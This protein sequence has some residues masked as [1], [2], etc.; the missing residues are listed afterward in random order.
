MSGSRVLVS[1]SLG[2]LNWGILTTQEMTLQVLGVE[3][4][5][6]AVRARELA[7]RILDGNDG[8][9]C[10][11]RASRSG[12]RASRSAGKDAA[13]ALRA[14]HVSRLVAIAHTSR[15]NG[16]RS[17]G[18]V[19]AGL[20]HDATSRH[21][22]KDGRDATGGRSRRDGLR[23]RGSHRGLGQHR[24][25]A[26]ALGR[27]RVLAHLLVRTAAS[28]LSSRLL[29]VGGHV[30]RRARSVG[31]RGGARSVRVAAVHL[32][33]GRGGLRLKRRQSLVRQ[34]RVGVLQLVRRD[35]GRRRVGGRARVYTIGR[36]LGR[37]HAIRE[38]DGLLSRQR[39][40][41]L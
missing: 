4:S 36:V 12:G 33:H 31:G 23:V 38:S 27:G 34:G 9:L 39:R 17:V 16:A 41:E 5:L 25:S 37:V 3:V 2:G 6:G 11:A 35:C 14:N 7:V 18:R 19:H 24:L 29:R 28:S 13:A 20:R 21:G 1:V 26:V 32:V 10:V 30:V 15:E 8:A 40:T 22:A